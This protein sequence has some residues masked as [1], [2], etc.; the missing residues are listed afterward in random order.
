LQAASS[1]WQPYAQSVSGP[2]SELAAQTLAALQ[3]FAATQAVH[4]FGSDVGRL[5][6][7]QLSAV[8]DA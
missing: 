6:L 7:A 3:Q 2:Q 1:G 5:T 8:F 4:A